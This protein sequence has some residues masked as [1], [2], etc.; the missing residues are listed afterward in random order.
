MKAIDR[1]GYY[2]YLDMQTTGFYEGKLN[3]Y[4]HEHKCAVPSKI[5]MMQEAERLLDLPAE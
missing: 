3:N 2:A 5:L 1:L 4:L